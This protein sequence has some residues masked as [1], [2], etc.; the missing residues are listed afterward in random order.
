MVKGSDKIQTLLDHNITVSME[1]LCRVKE[2]ED[3]QAN[4]TDSLH[5][6][7]KDLADK[8]RKKSLD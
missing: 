7:H 6:L 8:Q 2:V 3:K 5:F 1:T 4:H